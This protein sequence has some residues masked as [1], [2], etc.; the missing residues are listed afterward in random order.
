MEL[1]DNDKRSVCVV[2][3]NNLDLFPSNSRTHFINHFSTVICNQAHSRTLYAR[4]KAVGLAVDR[5]QPIQPG[6]VKV[7]L[8]EIAEQL[9]GRGFNRLLGGFEHPQSADSSYT[10]KTF[11]NTPYL[12]F[13]Q[14]ALDQLH[15][16]LTDANDKR[17]RIEQGPPTI[18]LIEV[19]NESNMEDEGSFNIT[20]RSNDSENVYTH[21]LPAHFTS[22]LPELFDLKNY[23]VT[24]LN[25]VYPNVMSETCRVTIR[26]EEELYTIDLKDDVFDLDSF[27]LKVNMEMG[28]GFFGQELKFAKL[29]LQDGQE[30]VSLTREKMLYGADKY[31][32]HQVQVTMSWSL[33]KL[34]GQ[35]NSYNSLLMMGVGQRVVFESI[36]SLD[37]VMPSPVA[38][39]MCDVVKP[40]WVGDSM[41]QLLT[42]LPVKFQS[43]DGTQSTIYEP[44]HLHYVDVKE[45]PFSNITFQFVNPGQGMHVR[46]FLID[47]ASDECVTITLSF[48]P[49][50]K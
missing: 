21:N 6:Y 16:V 11:G 36:P 7:Q 12:P 39:L 26:V 15:I 19:V 22:A 23:E 20:C 2:S 44:A 34:L 29:R 1:E 42:C 9:E 13:R 31:Q 48:R 5:S 33:L 25:V 49:K 38:M 47:S 37:N 40:G 27:L 24:L 35:T 17:F 43:P 8:Y 45:T 10:Y 46:E 50:R 14:A 32:Q 3:S 18:I 28:K 41:K 30:R 4:L